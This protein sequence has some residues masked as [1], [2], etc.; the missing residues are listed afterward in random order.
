MYGAMST[1]P[2]KARK[3]RVPRERGFTLV[4]MMTVITI[5]GIGAALAVPSYTRWN[6][7][8]Q[9]RQ[10]VTEITGQLALARLAAMNRNTSVNV[11]VAAAGGRV[12]VATADVSGAQVLPT[13]SMMVHV[14]DVRGGPVQFNSLGLRSGGG[15][16]NQ[17]ITVTNNQGLTYSIKVTP[18][19]KAT[20][21]AS[22]T[23]P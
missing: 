12:T 3:I 17:I 5:I 7:R 9:L 19:G 1:S 21:C 20:W 23:C 6:A 4:E 11:T 15:A 22:P 16:G 13:Q 8:Y 2:P 18:G 10:A 14:T